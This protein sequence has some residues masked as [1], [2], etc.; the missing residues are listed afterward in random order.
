MILLQAGTNMSLIN[1]DGFHFRRYAE[2]QHWGRVID[3]LNSYGQ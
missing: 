3:W 2:G 1:N